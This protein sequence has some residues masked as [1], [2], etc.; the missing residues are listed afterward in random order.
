MDDSTLIWNRATEPDF[1]PTRPGDEALAAVIGFH[2]LVMNG[3]IS[4]SLEVDRQ[5]T[6]RAAAG[7]RTLGASK[8]AEVV[9]EACSVAVSAEE[10]GSDTLDLSDEDAER[11]E[12]LEAKDDEL[13]PLDAA[14]VDL[15]EAY[16]AKHPD[17]FAPVA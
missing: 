8:I 17:H 16:R 6:Q 15:F 2:G 9:D 4:H 3:G 12:S 1:S 14:L 5:G 11:L 10:A 7:F 13:V